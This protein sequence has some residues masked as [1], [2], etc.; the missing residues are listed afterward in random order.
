MKAFGAFRKSLAI[1]WGFRTGSI[2]QNEELYLRECDDGKKLLKAVLGFERNFDE[3][4][5]NNS[6]INENMFMNHG[7]KIT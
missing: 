6:K 4:C 2:N 1:F 3:T 5:W 7:K